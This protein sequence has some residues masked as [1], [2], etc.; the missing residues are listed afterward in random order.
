[1]SA[2]PAYRART[3][4]LG[5]VLGAETSLPAVAEFRDLGRLSR[6][7]GLRPKLYLERPPQSSALAG[8]QQFSGW[9]GW[10]VWGGIGERSGVP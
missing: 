5:A 8:R 2:W 6:S 9:G 10:L 7:R 1:M 4:Q 3:R